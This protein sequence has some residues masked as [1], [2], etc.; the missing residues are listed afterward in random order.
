M[1]PLLSAN[2]YLFECRFMTFALCHKYA[3]AKAKDSKTRF[4]QL[5]L[6]M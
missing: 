6:T 1:D 4:E 5:D 2:E 3:M